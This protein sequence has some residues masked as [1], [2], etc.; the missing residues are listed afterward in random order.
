MSDFS[1]NMTRDMTAFIDMCDLRM[2]E[3]TCERKNHELER[4]NSSIING[5]IN[6]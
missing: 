1:L 2:D 4:A 6:R 5:G 3:T